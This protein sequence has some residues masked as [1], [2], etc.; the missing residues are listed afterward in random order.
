M[1]KKLTAGH[2]AIVSILILLSVI[3]LYPMYYTLVLSFSE[4][5]YAD[6]NLVWFWP[7]GFNLIS[8]MEILKDDVFF[9]ATWVSVK[10]VVVGC[11][12]TMLLTIMCA[13]PFSLPQKFFPEG[14]FIKWFFVAN[15][16]FSGGLIPSYVLMK[17]YGLHNNFW[18]L[19]LPGVSLGNT[20]LL[21]NFYRN[22][23]YELNE[24]A[25]IDGASPFQ[26]LFRIYVPLSKASLACILLFE[27]VGKWNAYFT[28]MLYI[29]DPKK[30]PLQTYIYT[31]NAKLD[32]QNM[33]SEELINALTMSNK[34]LNAAKIVVAM[35][36][37]LLIYP[38]IQRYFVTGMHLGAVKG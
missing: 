6:A 17:Q 22:V 2:V 29:N 7:K 27:F 13:Y 25:T 34:T 9:S 28:G 16:L 36:P 4:R 5:A 15:M 24:S 26:I 30:Q 33:T 18:I 38:F 12:L 37:I 31:M 10:V 1:K 23:P 14:R 8:Y 3:S 19:V 35:I 11:S 21:I 32:L 20:I